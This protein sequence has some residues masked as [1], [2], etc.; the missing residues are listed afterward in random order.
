M[1]KI[2]FYF[3]I[4]F[5]ILFIRISY[6]LEVGDVC[7]DFALRN[8]NG[9]I[10]TFSELREDAQVTILELI[11]IY[12][13]ACRKKVPKLNELAEKYDPGRVKIIAV[14]LANEQ[15]EINTETANW[16]AKYPILADPDKTTLHLYGIHNVPQFFIIDSTGIIRYSGN[17][18]N[19]KDIE[20]TTEKLLSSVTSFVQ[21]GDPAPPISLPDSN[22]TITTLDFSEVTSV[23]VLAF[24]TSD[25]KANLQQAELLE[26]I[27]KKDLP[28][29]VYGIISGTFEGN[30]DIF[31]SVYCIN[32]KILID[33]NG[34]V[35]KQYGINQIPE[36]IIVSKSGR[37]RMRNATQNPRMFLQLF[38]QSE[39]V[40]SPVD[41]EDQIMD[42]LRRSMPQAQSIKPVTTDDTTIYVG[43]S[44][45]GIKSY[46]RI[47]K[48]DILCEVCTDIAFVQVI[49]QE[50]VYRNFI[51][52]KPFES[53]GKKIDATQFLKQ[54]IG[55]SYHQ[56][57]VSGLN[58]DTISGATKSCMKF[59]EG[60]NENENI[61]KGFIDD[62]AFD[63][64]FRLKV[65]FLEQS[66]IELAMALYNHDHRKPLQDVQDVA[67]YCRDGKLPV[68]PS[69][70]TYVIVQFNDIP[71]VM[72]TIHG[73]DPQSSMIH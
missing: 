66:E 28:F 69:G 30:F 63:A 56:P 55:K 70:G 57:I 60:L 3:L 51:L 48:K 19:F 62:P 47:V 52:I 65:C 32:C 71:R 46:A 20:K 53:Y 38:E 43:T 39:S 1:K 72:C 14:A 45:D 12:C 11:S 44:R 21:P 34:T 13:D 15:P 68:C 5:L 7:K 42:A 54:F 40:S 36:T 8:G 25:N 64:N 24:F 6:A 31:K 27:V 2:I 9:Q 37:V 35:F 58:I 16:G 22:D 41:E 29:D 10:V 17:A 26:D 67:P 33:T 73:L 49:D 59:I 23:T 50:G 4:C 18:Q 61:F